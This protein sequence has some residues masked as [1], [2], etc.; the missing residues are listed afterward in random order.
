MAEPVLITHKAALLL[1]YVDHTVRFERN[2]GI[3]RCV[4][5]LGSALLEQRQLLVP[6]VWD[7]KANNLKAASAA[8]RL[9]LA[10]WGGPDPAQWADSKEHI[11]MADAL[12]L[13]IPELVS[14]P[15]N[16]SIEQVFLE[17]KKLDVK[18]AWLF[19][20]AIPLRLPQMYGHQSQAAAE[21]HAT[22]MKGLARFDLILAN[23]KTTANHLRQF[24]EQQRIKPAARLTAV[25]LAQEFPAQQR[26]QKLEGEGSIV[27][28]VS[29]L[30]P[31][32]NH[33]RLLKALIWLAA[34][35]IWPVSLKLVLVGWP[36]DKQVVMMVNRALSLGLP[37]CWEQSVDDEHLL[38]LYRKTLFCVY[39]S[40]E[41]GYG[42]PVAESLWHRRPCLCS[43]EG[44]VGELAALGG[45]LMVNTRDW[46]QLCQGLNLMLIGKELRSNLQQAIDRRSLRLWSDVAN[47]WNH[48]LRV[49]EVIP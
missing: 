16:P 44:A 45:C 21:C 34:H 25:P 24:W 36:N 13:I 10:R 19:H 38:D 26:L 43:G 7:R 12:W 2:T 48:E 35:R 18:V 27:L 9:H 37:L 31:R 49:N 14:G 22:Y 15:H 8:S 17:S 4:R 47:E 1:Y 5:C 3:Q 30:E 39:P 40:L 28:C 42:L 6:V 29:S 23:S 41:E 33:L 32:K 20:D 11:D 46:K